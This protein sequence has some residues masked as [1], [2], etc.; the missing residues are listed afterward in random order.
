MLDSKL[1]FNKRPQEKLKQK[2][3]TPSPG[4]DIHYTLGKALKGGQVRVEGD[5]DAGPGKHM[6]LVESMLKCFEVPRLRLDCST[7]SKKMGFWSTPSGSYLIGTQVSGRQ[8]DC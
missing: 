8:R 3:I 1:R 4:R 7:Q 5:R 2:F 6:H